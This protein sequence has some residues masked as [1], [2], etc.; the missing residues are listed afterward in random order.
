L[1]NELSTASVYSLNSSQT[2]TLYSSAS[3]TGNDVD[4]GYFAVDA[5]GS[6]YT[7]TTFA[8]RNGA[9]TFVEVYN[10]AGALIASNDNALAGYHIRR[11]SIA[12]LFMVIVTK[13]EMTCLHR[14]SF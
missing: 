1:D 11:H 8:L 10:P 4:Y 6:Q 5:A 3:V 14:E 2:H 7:I 13:M 12:I 9:D